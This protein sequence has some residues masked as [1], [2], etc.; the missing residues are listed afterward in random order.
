MSHIRKATP[1]LLAGAFRAVVCTAPISFLVLM[2]P[3]HLE[4]SVRSGKK[5]HTCGKT[6]GNCG[7]AP[8]QHR[9][10]SHMLFSLRESRGRHLYMAASRVLS[11]PQW[12]AARAAVPVNEVVKISALASLTNIAFFCKGLFPTSSKVF[13]ITSFTLT[14]L[15]G[16]RVYF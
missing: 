12:L 13:G 10:G 1:V 2:K 16:T 15:R 9:A 7:S 14:T 5:A 11:L 4:G 8:T 6:Q 3:V